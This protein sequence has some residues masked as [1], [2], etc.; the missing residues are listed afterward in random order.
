MP[1]GALPAWI[2]ASRYAAGG[3]GGR[4]PRARCLS[5]HDCGDGPV[6]VGGLRIGSVRRRAVVTAWAHGQVAPPAG[7]MLVQVTKAA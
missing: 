7:L 1:W 5:C 6:L 4:R 2:P 3:P